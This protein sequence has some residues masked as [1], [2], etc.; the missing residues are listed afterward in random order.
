VSGNDFVQCSPECELI[1]RPV[2]AQREAHIEGWIAPRLQLIQQPES[3][4]CRRGRKNE[5][6]LVVT[7]RASGSHVSFRIDLRC[8]RRESWGIGLTVTAHLDISAYDVPGGRRNKQSLSR[9]DNA[10]GDLE[11]RSRA[12]RTARLAVDRH[13]RSQGM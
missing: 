10:T 3:F 5:N 6:G 8:D 7:W 11:F 4:L 1:E 2:P 9:R 12:A 13:D